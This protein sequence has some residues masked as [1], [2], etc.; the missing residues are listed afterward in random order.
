MQKQIPNESYPLLS[1]ALNLL[2][3]NMAPDALIGVLERRFAE[4]VRVNNSGADVFDAAGGYL[5]TFGIMGAVPGLMHT[6]SMLNDPSKIGSGIATAFV[7]TLYGGLAPRIF[8]R[9]RFQR[10]SA[11]AHRQRRNSTVL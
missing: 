2:V 6:M 4:N 1:T 3:S 11:L 10:R 9:I 5:P 8:W 7:A